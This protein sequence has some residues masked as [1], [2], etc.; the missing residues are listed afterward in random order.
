[1]RAARVRRG[2]SIG[3]VAGELGVDKVTISRWE[4]AQRWPS[5]EHLWAYA[6]SV[7]L[8]TGGLFTKDDARSTT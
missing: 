7:G 2:L 4:T 1:M 8:D 6:R 3:Q 5:V